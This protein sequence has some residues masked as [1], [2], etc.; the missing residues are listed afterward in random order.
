MILQLHDPLSQGMLK[1]IIM[2]TLDYLFLVVV[3]F[4]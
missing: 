3:K 2:L 1:I 4:N